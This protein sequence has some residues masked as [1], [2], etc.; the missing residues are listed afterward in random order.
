MIYDAVVQSCI[1]PAQEEQLK[2]NTTE[3]SYYTDYW[4]D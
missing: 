2:A 1:D 4:S 3:V